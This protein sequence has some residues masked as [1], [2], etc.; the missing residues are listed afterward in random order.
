[1]PAIERD[2]ELKDQ[3]VRYASANT[4][5]LNFNLTQK[6]F[7]DLKVRQAFAYAFDRQTYCE[8]L[9][10]G[11]CVSRCALWVRFCP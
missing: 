2:A 5:Y 8:V 7:D 9:W 3:V 1:M 10:S 6:P 11:T 4:W